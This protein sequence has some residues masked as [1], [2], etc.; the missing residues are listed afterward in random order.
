MRVREWKR[1]IK[2][3]TEERKY[4]EFETMTTAGKRRE[5]KAEMVADVAWLERRLNLRS[6]EQK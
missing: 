2:E 1:V 3:A 6:G 4:F 5:E